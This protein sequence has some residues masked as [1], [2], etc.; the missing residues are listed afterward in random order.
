MSKCDEVE[1]WT[2][3][4]KEK[5]LVKR[6]RF[7]FF[8]FSSHFYHKMHMNWVSLLIVRPFHALSYMIHGQYYKRNHSIIPLCY[9]SFLKREEDDDDDDVGQRLE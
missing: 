8:I 9:S 1:K 5:K 6:P 2:W 3:I 7:K 4:E